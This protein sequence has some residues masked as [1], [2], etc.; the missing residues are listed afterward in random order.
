MYACKIPYSLSFAC[1]LWVYRR[2]GT[3]FW[4]AVLLLADMNFGIL[5]CM[6]TNPSVTFALCFLFPVLFFG[7]VPR[8][9]Y[10]RCMTAYPLC[11]FGPG[12]LIN[13]IQRH[14]SRTLIHHL[15]FPRIMLCLLV[16]GRMCSLQTLGIASCK[17]KVTST[18]LVFIQPHQ[19]L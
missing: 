9:V 8:A 2:N 14:L 12:L 10:F 1:F 16:I 15:A 19:C 4:S 13:A 7:A 18:A 11:P 6:K 3:V 5:A 17:C